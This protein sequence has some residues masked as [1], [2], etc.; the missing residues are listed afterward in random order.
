MSMAILAVGTL[1][2]DPQERTS[3]G[4]KTYVTATVRTPT[5]DDPVMVS[6]ITFGDVPKATLIALK[7][8]DTVAISGRGKLTTWAGR[9]GEQRHGISVVADGVLSHPVISDRRMTTK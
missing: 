2:S 6:A 3:S 7:K 9:N 4:G 1:T 8:G 5:D